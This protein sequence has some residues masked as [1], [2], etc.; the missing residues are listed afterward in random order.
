[1]LSVK[2]K[3]I[4]GWFGLA[5]YS[6]ATSVAEATGGLDLE[7]AN[8]LNIAVRRVTVRNPNNRSCIHSSSYNRTALEPV[9]FERF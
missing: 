3:V 4:L 2:T 8:V 5:F 1:M 7:L 9:H 6:I